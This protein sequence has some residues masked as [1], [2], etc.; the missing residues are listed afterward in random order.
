MIHMDGLKRTIEVQKS[1]GAI[2]GDIDAT[3]MID[4]RFLPDD[5]KALQ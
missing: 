4:T 1:V 3:T 5:I 2:S